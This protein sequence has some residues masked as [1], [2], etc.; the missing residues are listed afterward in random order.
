VRAGALALLVAC[1]SG[2]AGTPATA[3]VGPSPTDVPARPPGPATVVITL[4]AHVAT[5]VLDGPFLITT[6]NPGSSMEMAIATSHHCDEPALVWFGYSGGGVAVARAQ[7][8][9]VRTDAARTNGFSGYDPSTVV[10]KP[11]EP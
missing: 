3:P 4:Q 7:T 6:I 1:K 8:L 5:P 2:G 11:P 9:C 10:A